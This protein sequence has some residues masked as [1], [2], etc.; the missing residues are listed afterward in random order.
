MND[1]FIILVNY[2]NHDDTLKCLRSIVE[3]G[4]GKSV[5]VVDN[6]STEIGVDE[7][8]VQY[9]NT[10]LIKNE[11]NL[12]FGRANNIGINIALTNDECEYIF[13]LNND[14]LIKNNTID[15][16]RK[17][18]EKDFEIAMA[19]PRIVIADAPTEL[20][21]GGGDIDWKKGSAKT[22][23]Y[24]GPIDTTLALCKRYV[25]FAS[26]CAMFFKRHALETLRGFDERFFMYC[27]DV[28][29]CLRITKNKMKIIYVPQALV[30][31]R[32]QGSQ[33]KYEEK[34]FPMLHP[35]NPKLEYYLYHNI[36]NRFI[37][38]STHANGYAK[39]KFYSYF[40]V[41]MLWKCIGYIAYGKFGAINSVLTAVN[42]Y[43]KKK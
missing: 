19:T 33:R 5:I 15:A 34:L 41:Y 32:C 1:T 30:F 2:N 36:K 26:G 13:I 7:I 31:H 3:A 8:K 6:N 9:P 17:E 29:L 40:Q 10:I 4:Y 38:V 25:T 35:L 43:R 22:P 12:G 39:I 24:L 28:E 23:G 16:L 21:Y 27:E 20:W 14:T 11:E 42:D 18:V 37:L